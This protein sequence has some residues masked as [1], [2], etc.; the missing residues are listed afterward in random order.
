MVEIFISK[1]ILQHKIIKNYT[2]VEI[3]ISKGILQH[4]II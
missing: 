4:K 2:M 3:F 1:G